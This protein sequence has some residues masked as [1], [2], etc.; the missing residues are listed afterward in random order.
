M[1]E[2]VFTSEVR[3]G[4]T[5]TCALVWGTGRPYWPGFCAGQALKPEGSA[6]GNNCFTSTVSLQ[7]SFRSYWGLFF[8][9]Q[10]SW[11]YFLLLTVSPLASVFCS[12]QLENVVCFIANQKRPREKNLHSSWVQKKSRGDPLPT[13]ESS[14]ACSTCLQVLCGLVRTLPRPCRDM[15]SS[16][17]TDVETEASRDCLEDLAE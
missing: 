3:A 16:P 10:A 2:E 17:F 14:A 15:L 7:V 12:Q 6:S 4:R 1:T 9:F 11:I 13:A 8:T 5:E